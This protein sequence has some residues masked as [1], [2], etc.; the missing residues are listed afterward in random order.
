M[1]CYNVRMVMYVLFVL[2]IFFLIKGADYLIDGASS[3]AKKLGVPTLVIGLTIVAFGTSTPE[4]IVSVMAAIRQVGDVAFGNVV[5][6]NIANIL[7]ILGVS[8][9]IGNLKVQH[10]TTWKEIPFSLL[11]AAALLVFSVAHKIDGL[12]QMIYRFEGMI[13]LLFFLIFMYYVIEMAHRNKGHMEDKNMKVKLRSPIISWSMISVGLIGLYFGGRW[14]VEGATFIAQQWGLS[15]LLISSTVVAIGTSLPELVTSI[16][17]TR[18]GDVDLAIGSV[19]GSNIFNI[20]WILGVSA[21]IYPIQLPNSAIVDVFFLFVATALL[22][23]S[24]FMGKR[25]E[26]ERWQGIIFVTSYIVYLTFLI[27]RG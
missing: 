15:Q 27:W 24:M 2:G 6:S 22:F 20:L 7:L 23:A 19:V 11:A 10:S 12:G 1:H 26:L 3:I 25:H 14:V 9:I 4:L 21:L 8:A 5:G 16:V 17:A 13:L 18:K